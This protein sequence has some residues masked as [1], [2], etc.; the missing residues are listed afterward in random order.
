MSGQRSWADIGEDEEDQKAVRHESKVD[1]NGIK[2]I[3]E[4]R[5]NERDQKVK[6]TRRVKVAPKKVRRN[7]IVEARKQWTKFGDCTGLPAGPEPNITYVSY[8][9]VLLERVKKEEEE[10]PVDPW[11]KLTTQQSS[12]VVC[13]HCGAEGDHWTLKCPKR[14]QL[15]TP[16]DARPPAESKTNTPAASSAT[17]KASAY[18]PPGARA[19][20]RGEPT[21]D[22]ED[23]PTVRVTNLSE[24]TAEDDLRDLFRP[25]GDVHRIYLGRDRETNRPKGYAYVAFV[26]RDDAARAIQTLDGYGYD[27]LILH[28]DWAEKRK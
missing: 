12:I 5:T 27:N 7:K 22:K 4:Y 8:E 24:D 1:A 10:K 6:V 20:E 23:F 16:A 3:T 9:E 14:L 21:R 11:E 17:A 15:G 26:R 2:I 18:V 13:R 25:F 19:R 28:L